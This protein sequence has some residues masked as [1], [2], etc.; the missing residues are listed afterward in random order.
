[1]QLSDLLSPAISIAKS[2]LQAIKDAKDW[3]TRSVQLYAD[4]AILRSQNAALMQWQARA[5]EMEAENRALRE[6]M[7]VIPAQKH[8]FITARLVTDNAGPYSHSAL[9]MGENG[10]GL[11]KNRAVI[12]EQGLVGR[13]IEAG[14]TS[15]RVLLLNDMNSRVPVMSE[16]GHEKAIM[17]GSNT[18]LPTLSYLPVNHKLIEGDRIVTSGDGGVFPGGIPVGLIVKNEAGIVEVQP[19]A[20]PSQVEYVSI[21]AHRP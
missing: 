18:G 14:N 3:A 10:Q 6:L 12:N 5:K 19:F 16:R 15:A 1:V 11:Q 9:I 17:V 8:E 13:V 4:N 7:N 20:N 21:I 2:P